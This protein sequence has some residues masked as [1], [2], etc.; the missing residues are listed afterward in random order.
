MSHV[1]VL[2][3]SIVVYHS[4][5]LTLPLTYYAKTLNLIRILLDG[6]FGLRDQQLAEVGGLSVPDKAN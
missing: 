2:H 5:V 1:Q 3:Q 6:K 4:V